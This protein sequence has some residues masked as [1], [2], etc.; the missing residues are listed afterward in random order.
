MSSWNKSTR[1]LFKLYESQKPLD[2]KTGM[3]FNYDN[4]HGETSTQSQPVYDKFNE[5][6][7]VKGGVIHDCIESIR[8]D[9]QDTS[10]LDRKGKGKVGVGYYRPENS[11]SGWLKNKLNKDKA[12]AGPKFFV[13]NQPRHYSKKAKTEWTRN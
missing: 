10:Q 5:R 2:D 13:P 8:Y 3:G 9:D 7:F 11:K 12:K 1:S 4:S 6:T